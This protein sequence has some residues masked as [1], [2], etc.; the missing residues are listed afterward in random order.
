MVHGY[1][2]YCLDDVFIVGIKVVEVRLVNHQWHHLN[3]Q[4]KT[5]PVAKLSSGWTFEKNNLAL[6]QDIATYAHLNLS[7]KQVFD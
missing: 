5:I 2:G 6:S 7:L 1:K 3:Q 4:L